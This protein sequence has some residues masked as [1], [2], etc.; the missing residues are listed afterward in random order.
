MP[1]LSMTVPHS[2]AQDEAL[3]RIKTLLDDVKT[4]HADKITDLREDWNGYIGTF[5]FSAMGFHVSGTLTVK[6]S[7]VEITGN[8]PFAATLF[9]SRIETAIRERAEELLG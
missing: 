8:L 9:K 3:T 2:L 4:R 7:Q 5:A 1:T 6:P